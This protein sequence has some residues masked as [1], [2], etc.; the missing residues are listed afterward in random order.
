M[1]EVTENIEEKLLEI[2][3]RLSKIQSLSRV[4]QVCFDYED[5]LKAG[6]I[7]IVFEVIR[8]KMADTKKDFSEIEVA[9]KI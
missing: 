7:E 3:V 6:D 1:E 2:G 4:M 9:L 5:N 8:S